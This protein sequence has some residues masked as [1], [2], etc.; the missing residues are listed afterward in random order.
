MALIPLSPHGPL[1]TEIAE[2]RERVL[3]TMGARLRHREDELRAA[4]ALAQRLRRERETLLRTEETA[5]LEGAEKPE[6][7]ARLKELYDEIRQADYNVETAEARQRTT[8]E[9]RAEKER[10]IETFTV[11][12]G[13]ALLAEVLPVAVEAEAHVRELVEQLQETWRAYE[14]FAFT[15]LDPLLRMNG[16][17][18]VRPSDPVN[19]TLRRVTEHFEQPLLLHPHVL[20]QLNAE[21]QAEPTPKRAVIVAPSPQ[22]LARM[23]IE[24]ERREDAERHHRSLARAMAKELRNGDENS[25]G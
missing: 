3:A 9:V 6:T 18:Q 1:T 16:A 12:H 20:A 22:E 13:A 15:E 11:E 4:R 5:A 17:P 8:A 14:V 7:A 10:E 19:A 21:P 25:D 23:Q 2:K 24:R